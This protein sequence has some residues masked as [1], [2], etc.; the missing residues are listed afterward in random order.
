MK[1]K[2]IILLLFLLPASNLFSKSFDEFKKLSTSDF[3]TYSKGV[4]KDFDKYKKEIEEAFKEYKTKVAK[5]WG[6]KNSVV[7]D[8]KQYVSYFNKLR[9][10]NIIDFEEGRV[11]IEIVLSSDQ[12]NDKN[13]KSKLKE[14][15]KNAI[16]QKPDT[17]SI[18]EISKSPDTI[19]NDNSDC[20]LKDQIKDKNGNPVDLENAELFALEV[21][22][23]NKFESITIKDD[24]NNEKT[25]VSIDFPLAEDHIKKRALRYIDFVIPEAEKR[26]I[27]LE[28]IF[29]IMETESSFNPLAKSPIPAFGL[30]QLVPTTAGRDSFRFIYKKDL[31]PSDKFLYQ[32]KNNIELGSAYLYILFNRYLDEVENMDSRLWCV[33]AAY[34]TGIGNLFQTFV[35][36]YSETKFGTRQLWKLTAFKKINGM[37]PDEVYDYLYANLPYKETRNY[38]ERVKTRMPKYKIN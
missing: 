4:E 1:K 13:I 26:N 15:L 5:V 16:I 18:T 20:L 10:R 19:Q 22:E 7:S 37:S 28:L 6:E 8:K 29:A 3:K 24:E 21:L 33:V 12:K 36:E 11:K 30:M 23:Q 14:S 31:A 17:R 27:D 9:E 25:I 35:G 2:L 32:P 38:I 34:N